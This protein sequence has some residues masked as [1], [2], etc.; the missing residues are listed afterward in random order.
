MAHG[1]GYSRDSMTSAVRP[2]VYRM[3]HVMQIDNTLHTAHD[4]R[5]TIRDGWYVTWYACMIHDTCHVV[6]DAQPSMGYASDV[7]ICK[8]RQ[9]VHFA[10]LDISRE[11]RR[12]RYNAQ[13]QPHP[14]RAHPGDR[15]TSERPRLCDIARCV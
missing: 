2:T 3:R 12:I 9:S 4:V 13:A 10:Y 1:V 8:S 14:P 7:L 11:A 15:P 5:C 6:C